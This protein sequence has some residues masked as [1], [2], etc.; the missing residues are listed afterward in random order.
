MDRAK[1]MEHMGLVVFPAMKDAFQSHDADAYAEFKCQTCHGDD[2][3]A[4]DYAMPT[5][6]T[7]LPVVGTIEAANDMDEKM[8]ALMVE[9]VQP[10]MTEMLNEEVTC[11]ACHL[12][13]E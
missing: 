5:A 4:D 7:P 10:K 12:K 3:E 9:V 13:D 8:T 11:F 2:M 1:R 6:I